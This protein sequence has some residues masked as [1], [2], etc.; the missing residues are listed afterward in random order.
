VNALRW[1][2][3]SAAGLVA[4]LWLVLSVAGNSFRSSFGASAHGP[5]RM[6]LPVAVAL[7]L[8]AAPF[9]PERRLVLHLGAVISV[10]LLLWCVVLVRETRFFAGVIAIYAASW[11][12]YYWRSAWDASRSIP[13]S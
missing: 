13:T 12:W 4:I 9:L 2:L 3:A 10:G 6:L 8:M 1:L 11:L 7:V 5:L